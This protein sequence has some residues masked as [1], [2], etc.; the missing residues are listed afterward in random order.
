MKNPMKHRRTRSS[1]KARLRGE[2]YLI[3]AGVFVAALAFWSIRR[4]TRPQ[5]VDRSGRAE[6]P[7]FYER[8]DAAKPFP[9]TLSPVVFKDPVVAHAYEI[10]KKSPELMVQL[11]CYCWC[12]RDMGHRSLLDCYASIHSESC[13]ICI[14]EALLAETMSR[15]G[16]SADEIRTALIRGDWKTAH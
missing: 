11:P 15:A 8:A 6:V 4:S 9:A 10:A 1:L 16:K 12:S 2:L 14:K 13:D 7:R 3:M 5:H